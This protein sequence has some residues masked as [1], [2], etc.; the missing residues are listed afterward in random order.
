MSRVARVAI[1]IAVVALAGCGIGGGS[2]YADIPG[3]GA[4]RIDVP[5]PTG[6]ASAACDDDPLPPAS[7]T[8]IAERVI[9]M[10][11]VGL[12]AD[13]SA[14]SDEALAAEIDA[15]VVDTWGDPDEIPQDLIDLAVAQQDHARVWWQDVEADVTDGND[16]YARTLAEWGQISLG[17]FE[18]A[19]ITETWKGNTGPVTVEFSHE[20]TPQSLAPA[21]LED[22]IDLGILVGINELI[23]GSGR[24]FDLYKAFDQTAFVMA[25]TDDER[26]ALEARGWCFE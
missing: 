13:R 6:A 5:R 21:Y 9:A 11:E 10:R 15:A 8:A 22:W 25:L 7:D 14:S 23:A 1:L 18:P 2:D 20:G 12:F 24:R 16:V 26:L 4:T 17:A 19:D 3:V